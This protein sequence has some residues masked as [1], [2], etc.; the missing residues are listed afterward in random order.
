MDDA[1]D[2]T[3]HHWTIYWGQP[4]QVPGSIRSNW[5][6]VHHALVAVE[7]DLGSHISRDGTST[8]SK[9]ETL[10]RDEVLIDIDCS[11]KRLSDA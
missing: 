7:A 1:V 3:I 8:N 6:V 5:Y 11:M 10:A 4:G 2:G 9:T